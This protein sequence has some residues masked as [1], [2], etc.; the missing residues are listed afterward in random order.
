[1]NE[2]PKL[3]TSRDL[4][5]ELQPGESV[6]V[7]EKVPPLDPKMARFRQIRGNVVAYAIN[8]EYALDSLLVE[9]I[10]PL[11]TLNSVIDDPNMKKAVEDL[12]LIV[13][14]AWLKSRDTNMRLKIEILNKTAKYH[15]ILNSDEIDSLASDLHKVHNVRN[16]FAHRMMVIKQR[17]TKDGFDWDVYLDY[18]DKKLLLDTSYFRGI[19]ELYTRS[20]KRLEDLTRKLNGETETEERKNSA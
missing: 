18:G 15:P 14:A 7:D 6:Y 4:W 9:L 8:I 10:D 1:M 12:K 5:V 17:K 16:D 2:R 11:K 20:L 3:P 13:N 19:D